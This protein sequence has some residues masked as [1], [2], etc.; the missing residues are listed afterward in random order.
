MTRFLTGDGE[1]GTNIHKQLSNVDVKSTVRLLHLGYVNSEE[2][3]R[4]L[5]TS[6]IQVG[7]LH[8]LMEKMA[9]KS[10]SWCM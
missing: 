6:T 3:G 2:V 7:K 8:K 1:S 10:T 5:K 9:R 4:T